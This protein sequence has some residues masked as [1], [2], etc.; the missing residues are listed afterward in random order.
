MLNEY[1]IYQFAKDKLIQLPRMYMPHQ[2][3]YTHAENVSEIV[4]SLVD[5]TNNLYLIG[6]LHDVIEDTDTTY[7]QL[8]ELVG[9]EI[10]NGVKNLTNNDAWIKEYGR[11]QYMRINVSNMHPNI[12]LVKLADRL[13]NVESALESRQYV[14][15]EREKKELERFITKYLCET[16]VIMDTINSFEVLTDLENKLESEELSETD[17][18]IYEGIFVLYDKIAEILKDAVY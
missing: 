17:T 9:K 18:L 1:E 12:M 16:Y 8:T 6:L 7:E 14:S 2:N 4:R 11:A 13:D 10:A 15:A 3:G 5:K